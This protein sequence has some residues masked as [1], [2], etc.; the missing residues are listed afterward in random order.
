MGSGNTF[1]LVPSALGVPTTFHSCWPLC[2]PPSV[3][4]SLTSA[5][6]SYPFKESRQRSPLSKVFLFESPGGE[7]CF[8][9]GGLTDTVSNF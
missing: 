8:L 4:Y 9:L 2:D 3:T 5:G 6:T 1:L 7:F